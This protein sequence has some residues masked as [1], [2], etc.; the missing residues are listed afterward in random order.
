[1]LPA[2]RMASSRG[3]QAPLTLAMATFSFVSQEL[4]VCDP[5]AWFEDGTPGGLYQLRVLRLPRGLCSVAVVAKCLL[6]LG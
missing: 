1:M 4:C 2:Q 6:Q 5:A 3:Q